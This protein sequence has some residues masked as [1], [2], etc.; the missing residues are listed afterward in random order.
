MERAEAAPDQPGGQR[1]PLTPGAALFSFLLAA[2]WGGNSVALK[3]GLDDAPPL[4]IGWM[5]FL[6]GGIVVLVWAVI[7]R[8][9]LWI[10]SH[11]WKRIVTLGLLFS[12][13]IAF[14][15]LAQDRTTAAHGV[16]MN[17]TFPL[18]VGMLSHFFVP[19]DRLT[20]GKVVGALIAYGGV[21]SVFAA[22]LSVSR[23]L[24]VGDALML[25]SAMLLGTRIVYTARAV[26]NI[27]PAKLLLAQAVAG[28]ASFA[29]VSAFVESEPYRFTVVLAVSLFYQGVVIAGFA[30]ISNL[31]LLKR[32]MPSHITVIFLSQPILGVILSR[33]ILDEPLQATLWLGASLVFVGSYLARRSGSG[34]PSGIARAS[35]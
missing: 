22:G 1:R 8:Q 29:L 28:I 33:L 11:E 3:A 9:N 15:N 5:R 32:Y 10:R 31:W 16:V 23:D 14:M 30:F 20:R 2:L 12:V 24:V 21:A 27:E 25:V 34:E 19:G 17:N 7:T 13:Q 35:R 6:L 26:E 18:W 4:R